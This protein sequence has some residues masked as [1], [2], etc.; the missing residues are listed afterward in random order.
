[1]GTSHHYC[2]TCA[3]ICDEAKKNLK[4]L[5]KKVQ[6]LTIVCTASITLLGEQ[7]TKALYDAIITF[8]KVT[9]VAGNGQKEGKQEKDTNKKDEPNKPGQ[10]KLGFGGWRPY[11]QKHL[12]DVPEKDTKYY[13]LSDELAKINKQPKEEKQPEISVV[14]SQATN[15]QFQE[16]L[17]FVP[18]TEQRINFSENQSDR[19]VLLFTPS[20]LPLDVYSAK[21]NQGNFINDYGFSANIAV[22]SPGTTSLIILAAICGYKNRSR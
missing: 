13:Q 5:E 17:N 8:N 19:Y 21:L 20:T 6:V 22:P 16:N 7:G 3:K 4:K 11:R 2:E 15:T 1:M 10:T 12:Y 9:E 18:L 14:A